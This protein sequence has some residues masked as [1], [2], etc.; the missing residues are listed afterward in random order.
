MIFLSCNSQPESLP[1]KNEEEAEKDRFFG[2]IVKDTVKHY[3]EEL[4]LKDL[5]IETVKV[6]RENW[7]SIST[8]AQYV[9]EFSK[10]L[11]GTSS[12]N[13]DTTS[14]KFSLQELARSKGYED[15]I[16]FFIDSEG[17][18]GFRCKII[19]FDDTGETD[20]IYLPYEIIKM[21]NNKRPKL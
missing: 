15:R 11:F 8:S 13:I 20:Y 1:A 4:D 6:N 12:N 2:L 7:L 10:G 14:T 19:R 21:L 5:R 3:T 16:V 18:Q 17:R 9:D